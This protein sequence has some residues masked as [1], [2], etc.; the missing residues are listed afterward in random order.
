MFLYIKIK[1]NK[2]QTLNLANYGKFNYLFEVTKLESW[3][4]NKLGGLTRLTKCKPGPNWF[5]GW[6]DTNLKNSWEVLESKNIEYKI[7]GN[8]K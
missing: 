8:G 5:I 2:Y 1:K 6:L 4:K 3:E 7:I